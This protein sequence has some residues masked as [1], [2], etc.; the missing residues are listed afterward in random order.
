MEQKR[1]YLLVEGPDEKT[2]SEQ[3]LKPLFEGAGYGWVKPVPYKHKTQKE[4]NDFINNCVN[5]QWSYIFLHDLDGSPC[6]TQRK[7]KI[8]AKYTLCDKDNMQVVVQEIE[9][10]YLAGVDDN[11]L[12]QLKLPHSG[13]TDNLTKE[14]FGRLVP[15]KDSLKAL[16]VEMLKRF[17]VATAV[18]KNTSFRYF[19]HKYGLLPPK[20]TI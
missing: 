16:K 9:S 10:W 7:D 20:E 14:E 5:N 12:K 17:S 8:Q 11:I 18:T 2:F 19:V 3:I 6:V 4:V 15:V 13:K 1:L